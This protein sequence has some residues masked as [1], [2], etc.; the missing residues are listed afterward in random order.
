MFKTFAISLGSLVGL[1]SVGLPAALAADLPSRKS[2]PVAY[3]KICDI[4]GRGYYYIP[5][6]DT[7]LKVGG[8][9]RFQAEY[10]PAYKSQDKAG[11]Y[12][13][14]SMDTLGWYSRAYM[15]MDARTR[16]A[17]GTVRSYL[18]IQFESKSGHL[19]NKYTTP[20]FVGGSVSANPKLNA[21]YI[22]FAG[23]T[24][25]RA[26]EIFDF[27]PSGVWGSFYWPDYSS[28]A[29]QIAYT[30]ILSKGLSATIGVEEYNDLDFAGKAKKL[31]GFSTADAPMRS[32]A[33]VG[34]LYYKSDW[35]KF[36]LM[37]GA[38]PNASLINNTVNTTWGYAV[39]AGV[40]L[41]LNQLAKGDTLNITGA[42]GDGALG[43][44]YS[45]NTSAPGT[46]RALGGLLRRDYN[47]YSYQN[48]AGG[49]SY[50]TTKAWHVGAMLKHY[51][52]PT[53]YSIFH[54]S[55]LSINPGTQTRATDWT[56]GGVGRAQAKTAS[57][58]LIWAPI[59]DLKIGGEIVYIS[60]N[61][62]L[63]GGA[64]ATPLAAG[65]KLNPTA[66]EAR[67]RVQ[68]DF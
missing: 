36:Q 60:L 41:K 19:N 59:K 13:A 58:S 67:F 25:G 6:T 17:Y 62:K 7:C 3:V 53:L 51:W 61:Q 55:Y 10:I 64:N 12:E 63:A 5:G 47:V 15:K 40:E 9:V 26:G 35:G 24:F 4:Y 28:G 34:N 52:S 2:G 43:W 14:R 31:S 54:A 11:V 30:A 23:F 45:S 42:Y 18:Q 33:V 57:A 21:A 65:V 39:G 50:E 44:I 29:Q 1:A 56:L 46:K 32:A 66:F 27:M 20:L 22:Q 38:V 37:A 49:T 68:R 48:A 8:R 16:T